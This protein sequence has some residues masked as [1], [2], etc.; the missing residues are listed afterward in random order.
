MARFLFVCHIDLS[1]FNKLNF[2]LSFFFLFSQL[3]LYIYL[4]I[5]L[6]WNMFEM[7]IRISV[8]AFVMH[9]YPD[10]NDLFPLIYVSTYRPPAV[11]PQLL[12]SSNVYVNF[13]AQGFI[14][15]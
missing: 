3:K 2:F 5:F 9:S 10:L 12:S 11:I 13:W 8:I 6:W 4:L 7:F 15:A 14:S 1:S